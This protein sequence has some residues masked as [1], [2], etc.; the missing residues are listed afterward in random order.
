L[1]LRSP[2]NG[3]LPSKEKEGFVKTQRR[4]IRAAALGLGLAIAAAAPAIAAPF[5]Q[6]SNA[7]G[8]AGPGDYF[9]SND[10]WRA[11]RVFNAGQTETLAAGEFGLRFLETLANGTPTGAAAYD[12]P[13]FCLEIGQAIALPAIYEAMPVSDALPAAKADPLARL[14]NA[15]VATVTDPASP[16]FESVPGATSKDRVAAFQV[17]IWEIAVDGNNG[18]GTGQFR[19]L[20]TDAPLVALSQAYLAIAYDPARPIGELRALISPDSQDQLDDPLPSDVPEPASA[21]LLAAALLGL[22][23]RR[24]RA[25]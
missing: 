17:A 10:H 22:G 9:L 20:T 15:R 13:T 21:A 18:L 1:L 6:L 2:I 8:G 24:R 3:N 23:L 25:G 7:P 11:V 4:S 19:L 16:V 14:W 12:L 5:F